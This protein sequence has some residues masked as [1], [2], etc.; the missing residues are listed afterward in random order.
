MTPIS[1]TGVQSTHFYPPA[2]SLSDTRFLDPSPS[3]RHHVRRTLMGIIGFAILYLLLVGFGIALAYGC[4]LGAIWLISFSINKFT[5]II[6]IGLL[7][8]GVMFLLFLV[9][10]LVAVNKNQNDQRIEVTAEEQPHLFAFINRLADEV[11]APKPYKI[12]VSPNVNACVFYNSSFWSLFLP[13]R[14]NLEIG[15]G[16][17]NSVNLSEFKAVMAHEFGHF[18]QRSMKLGS[19]VYIVNRVIYNLVYDRDRWDNLL[20]QWAASGNLFGSF[21]SLTHLLVNLVRRIL[22]KAYEWLNLRYMGLS[23]EMEYQADL[24]AV[25]AAG[26]QPIITALRR[27]ELGDAA[28][29]QLLNHLG[30][31]AE[32]SKVAQNIYS[33]HTETM[34]RLASENDIDMVNGL[35]VLNDEQASKLVAPNRVNYQDQWSSHPSQAE[36][37]L[38]VRSVTAF[39]TPDESSPWNLFSSPEYLQKQLTSRLYAGVELTNSA[40]KQFI[41]STE[42][43]A[44]VTAQIQRTQLPDCY[45]GFYDQ[46]LLFN[47]DPVIVAQSTTF[48][49]DSETLFSD[50]NRALRKQLFSNYEDRATLEQIK[51]KKIQTRSFDFDGKKY[52]Q[53]Q[54]DIALNILQADIETGRA[55]F[56]QAEE[57]AFRWH[58][59]RA[60]THKLGDELIRRVQLYF[61]IDADRETYSHL[62]DTYGELM[63]NAYDVLKDGNKIKHGMSGQIDELNEKI[64]QAYGDS[65]RIDMPTRLG[66]NEFKEGY[67]AYLWPNKPQPIFGDPVN[68]EQ[69]VTLYQQLESIPQAAAHAQIAVLDDLIRW[70]ATL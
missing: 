66:E 62:L 43:V 48:I 1:P 57:D 8:L 18:S 38:N 15:L 29:H 16:L 31:L 51:A 10:F 7:A 9:K 56:Q 58:Y 33:L 6:G 50:E 14:K 23:R 28:Y 4:V 40:T 46:R 65:Q 5:V 12:Y 22:G 19:Y 11:N 55:H 37:E 60:L 26:G 20:D 70:Q 69:M 59:Q 49:P 68:W 27:I 67:Q 61:Q 24:V 34:Y 44:Y 25:S 52:D 2:P 63:K 45:R 42:Y 53:N 64:Q 17:V 36:R 3:F 30:G 54:V 41:D 32:E 35:P 21:A 39:C 47:F 13:V